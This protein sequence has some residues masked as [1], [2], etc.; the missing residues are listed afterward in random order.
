MSRRAMTVFSRTVGQMRGD[1]E[2]VLF[3][4]ESETAPPRRDLI[5]TTINNYRIV[6]ELGRGGSSTVYLA[7]RMDEQYSAQ[8]AIKVVESTHPTIRARV[9]AERQILANLNHP[10]IARLLDA[11]ETEDRQPYLIME[12]VRGEPLDSYCDR[13]GLNLRAR[14]DLFMQICSAVSFAHQR[15]VVHRDLK[16]ANILVTDDGTPKL[17]DFGIAK[18][19]D[20]SGSSNPSAALT[21]MADR[22]LTREFA[23]PEQI[24]G[25][26]VTTTSDVY[27]LGVVLYGL[28][29]GLHP[30]R[31]S[32]E[33]TE[34]ELERLIVSTDPVSPSQA[35]TKACADA[36]DDTVDV[37]ATL[38]GTSPERLA[39]ALRGDL[40][41]IVMRALRKESAY[42][43]G[44]VEQ[45]A[46]DIRRYLSH[47]AVLARQGN[48]VYYSQR[49]IR[50]HAFGVSVSAGFMLMMAGVAVVLSLQNQRIRTER[51][52][53]ETVSEF[54]VNVF[55]AADPFVSL[56]K[57]KEMTA[58]ELLEQAGSRIKADPSL[59]PEVR[60][61][62]M[63]AIGRAY[64]RQERSDEGIPFLEEAL[65]LRREVLH[66]PAEAVGAVQAELASAYRAGGEFKKSEAALSDALQIAQRSHANASEGY[67]HL[68]AEI[69]RLEA[70][71]GK[72]RE[73]EKHLSQ[74]LT[75][76]R[77]L[78][79]SKHPEVAVILLDLVGIG[80]WQDRQGDLLGMAREAHAIYEATLPPQHPDRLMAKIELATALAQVGN[81]DEA[82]RLFLEVLPAQ[83]SLYGQN[84]QKVADTLDALARVRV[85]QGNLKEAEAY[86]REALSIQLRSQGPDHYMSGYYRVA[87]ALTL[88]KLHQLTEAEQEFKQALEVYARTLPADHQY[89]AAAEHWLGE[90][91][92]AEGKLSEAEVQLRTAI[93]RWQRS[94]APAWR[95]ARSQS[96]LGEALYRQGR[97]TDAQPYLSGSVAV[98]TG[99]ASV[100]PEAIES[101]RRRLVQFGSKSER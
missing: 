43:Y 66:S 22:M 63:Q 54:M 37:L 12:Y 97:G 58:S 14:L 69:G 2:G 16:P 45:L 75:Q 50:R 62:L 86:G 15:L 8:V 81:L 11:G 82:N 100:D 41:A 77:A 46:D 42:R 10:N 33:T 67:V 91:L 89:I 78:W 101:A 7:E 13:E 49:F 52:Q 35:V 79:G 90:T 31:I 30:Y 20:K 3:Y 39:R 80:R 95:A 60:A 24:Q 47:E 4:E 17:L 92:L 61:R 87:L 48:W 1:T 83:R 26:A 98:L 88:F 84:S 71:Q 18:L 94:G 19:L 59:G 99:A 73:A 32:D 93:A 56:G 57:D 64:R 65:H 51:E 76:A 55:T 72:P 21:R 25:Q 38:R 34:L 74:A 53:A 40:D 36:T 96:A 9:Q 23:S 28:L 85:A 5:G 44:S 70:A 29:T 68:L 6:S 27:A